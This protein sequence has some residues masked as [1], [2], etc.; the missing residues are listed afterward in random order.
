MRRRGR[1][2]A[3]KSLMT[4][5]DFGFQWEKLLGNCDTSFSFSPITLTLDSIT[6]RRIELPLVLL[7]VSSP[8][9]NNVDEVPMTTLIREH[10]FS[11]C[12]HLLFRVGRRAYLS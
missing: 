6:L 2:K 12:V 5:F 3:S 9:L 4:G 11:L 10:L 1:N 7:R 8:A